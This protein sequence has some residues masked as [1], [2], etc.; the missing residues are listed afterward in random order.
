MILC[1]VIGVLVVPGCLLS[2][3]KQFY[4]TVL[5]IFIMFTIGSSVS[6]DSTDGSCLHDRHLCKICPVKL[7]AW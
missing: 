1:V 7:S 6:M 3:D 2:V 4:L 5:F